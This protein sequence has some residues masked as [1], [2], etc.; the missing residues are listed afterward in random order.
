MQ[1]KKK[2]FDD[3]FA[4]TSEVYIQRQK[5]L[6]AGKTER[7]ERALLDKLLR[8]YGYLPINED[9]PF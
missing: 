6:D 4:L 1:M 9:L 5:E 3:R 7:I 2:D 8:K